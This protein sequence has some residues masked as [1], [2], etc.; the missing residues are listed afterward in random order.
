MIMGKCPKYCASK[1][2]IALYKD[3]PYIFTIPFSGQ[4]KGSL[5]PLNTLS[6]TSQ[7]NSLIWWASVESN[8][9]LSYVRCAL[10]KS[11]K[12]FLVKPSIWCARWATIPQL[13][14]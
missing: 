6:V 14:G 12:P 3:G 13:T 7:A 8:D 1:L 5:T 10:S 9:L 4:S 11:K 2:F